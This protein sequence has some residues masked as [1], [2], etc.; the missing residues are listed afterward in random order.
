MEVWRSIDGCPGY[1]VS[2]KGRVLCMPKPNKPGIRLYRQEAQESYQQ[3]QMA[4][5]GFK[6]VLMAHRIVAVAFIP[7]PE[8]KPLVNH[9]DGNIHNNKAT[10]LEWATHSENT[11]HYWD[12]KKD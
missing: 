10:N 11:Q 7:N 6:R 9:K 8:G 1:K 4:I 2:N 3:I 5:N 12:R